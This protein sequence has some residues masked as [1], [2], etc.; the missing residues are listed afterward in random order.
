MDFS[1]DSTMLASGGD[2]RRI[3]LW[4]IADRRH[5]HHTAMLTRAT[6]VGSLA[7]APRGRMLA[8]TGNKWLA[9]DWS[10]GWTR[11]WD[12]GGAKPVERG[13]LNGGSLMDPISYSP[14]GNA[15]IFSGTSSTSIVGASRTYEVHGGDGVL[16]RDGTAMVASGTSA[17]ENVVLW[18]VRSPAQPRK[19]ASLSVGADSVDQYVL[20]FHPKSKVVAVGIDGATQ[21]WDI[22]EPRH[23]NR[24]HTLSSGK[25]EVNSMDF[26]RDGHTLVI[27]SNDGA[28]IWD[29][30]MLPSA[31]A[32]PVAMACELAGG[33][34]TR[35]QRQ[36]YVP[37][38]DY[39]RVCPRT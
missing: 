34:L 36:Q 12:V 25:G 21:L 23:A 4:N 24:P 35:E 2:D 31:A 17:D 1:P 9:S 18:D 39:Q 16:N 20:A 13:R 15:V 22:G 10:D 14:G 30:G 32:N 29:L 27:G 11:F 26:A 28:E 6:P 37:G 8:A 5:P 3:F 38:I 33:G 7:F 19:L